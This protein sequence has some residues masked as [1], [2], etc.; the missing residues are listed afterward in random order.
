MNDTKRTMKRR[1]A[2]VWRTV[3]AIAGLLVLWEVLCRVTDTPTYLLPA[4][5]DVF[6]VLVQDRVSLWQHSMVTL[7]ET[8]LGLA[9]AIVIGLVL[10]LLMDVSAVLHDILQGILVISQSIPI[11]ALAPIL[12]IYLGFGMA[13]KILAVVL[14]CFYPITISFR[15]G[16]RD[17]NL[18]YVNLLKSMGAGKWSIYRLV[19]IPSA[20][21]SFFAGLKVSATYAISGALVGEWLS[22]Q[23][24]LGYYMLRQNSAFRLDRVFASVFLIVFWSLL[25]TGLAAL[26]QRLFTPGKGF[27]MQRKRTKQKER[28]SHILR[29]SAAVILAV[30]VSSVL[31]TSCRT[32]NLENTDPGVSATGDETLMNQ[33]TTGDELQKVRVILDYTINTN[34]SGLYVALE[35]GYFKEEGL[36]VEIVEPADGVTLQLLA[37][38]KGDFGVSYQEDLSYAKSSDM[39]LP[40]KAVA[41]IVQHNTSGFASVKEKDIQ[42]PA[43]FAGKTYAG[44][45]SESEAAVIRAIMQNAGVDPDSINIISASGINYGNL[46]SDVD[47]MWFFEGWDLVAAQQAGMDINYM[48]C[49]DLDERLDYYTPILVAREDTLEADPEMVRAF[50]RATDKGYGYAADRENVAAV[51]DILLKYA[52]DADRELLLASQEYLCS[53]YRAESP[54][55][56]LMRDE[57]WDR[58]TDFMIENK[59]IEKNVPAKE[60]YTNEFLP[61]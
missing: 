41:T 34:H 39:P 51:V 22:S 20:L 46:Q 15:E 7:Y 45:G 13:P 23:A 2:G 49:R 29:K 32:G 40:L 43:D 61:K 9:L 31:L 33:Q 12:M 37:A 55:W 54:Q 10:A 3:I 11:I 48:A 26:A 8:V 30:C 44:W 4:P 16:L 38:G 19:K 1:K 35:K 58:Y 60:L 56:G 6:K 18:S 28:A 57:V 14:M 25:F 42:T 52:P 36:D 24:G 27:F 17:V 53:E 50:L 5:T 47:L 21:I 59:L